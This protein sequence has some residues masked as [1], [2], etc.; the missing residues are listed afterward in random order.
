MARALLSPGTSAFAKKACDTFPEGRFCGKRRC[1]HKE[2]A[3][4]IVRINGALHYYAHVPKCGGRSVENYLR[5]RFGEMWLINDDFYGLPA[6]QRWT[7]SSPQHV[8]WASLTQV[9]P[10]D[11]FA[12]SLAVVRH[13][14]AR[15]VSSYN[16]YLANLKRIPIA[17]SME[18]W[19]A[20]FQDLREQHPF[21]L[22]NHMRPQSD[23]VPPDATVF[24]LEDGL[25]D[26]VAHLDGLAGDMAEP[27]A[28]AHEHATHDVAGM[29]KAPISARLLAD[30]HQFYAVDFERFGYDRIQEKPALIYVPEPA[31]LSGL[32]GLRELAR[33]ERRRMW[34]RMVLRTGKALT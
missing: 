2:L 33:L 13:P 1:S 16:Y 4:P 32:K 14:V 26:L 29:T 15:A 22:D 9:I 18:E 30:L 17:M 12:T 27:R 7:K 10:A 8:D 5:A 24:K 19:F 11:A 25:S 23:I 21:Y 6:H 20:E 28:V 31:R 34:K 3:M